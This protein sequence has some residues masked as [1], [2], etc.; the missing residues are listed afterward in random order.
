MRLSE[1][2]VVQPDILVVCEPARITPSHIE[3]TLDWVVE[4]LSPGTSAKDLREKKWLYQRTGVREYWVVDPL[5]LYVQRFLL[6]RDALRY[7]DSGRR[8]RA[9]WQA[10]WEAQRREDA[11]DAD[12]ARQWAG[13]PPEA[14]A[15]ERKRRKAAEVG[16][17]PVPPKYKPEDFREGTFWK[18]RGPLDVPKERFVSFPGLERPGDPGSPMLLWAGYETKGRALALAG[19]VYDIHRSEGSDPVRLAPALA[20]LD[21]WLPWVHQWHPEIDPDLGMTSGDYLQG[22]LDAQL[23]QLGLTLADVRAW[24]PPNTPRR[25]RR[26]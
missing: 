24:A 25:R 4:V 3:G 18:L 22:L 26:G 19:R 20:G 15:A 23:A 16:D 1:T 21:E 2:D 7:S 10:V 11:I 12:V 17:I 8:K 6:T 14:I 13:E 9:V 5:E